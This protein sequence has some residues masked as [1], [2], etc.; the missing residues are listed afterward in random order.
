M[1]TKQ[2]STGQAALMYGIILGVIS[3]AFSIILYVM[4]LAYER[5]WA[6]TVVS[7]LMIVILIAI[8]IYQYKISNNGLITLSQALKVGIGVA[9]IGGIFGLIYLAVLT[10]F[11]EPNFW[12]TTFE[13]AKPEMLAQNPKMTPAQVDEI[14]AMQKKF[15]WMTYPTILVFNLFIGFVVA[16]ITGLIVKKSE[17]T[18]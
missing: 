18:N 15:A 14:I 17:D 9:L 7:V 8:G 2:L 5:N 1:E 12:D 10:N 11:I 16:L 13:R 4:D 3:V 6:T